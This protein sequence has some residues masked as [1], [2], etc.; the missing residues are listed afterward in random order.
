MKD[1]ITSGAATV[2]VREGLQNWSVDRVAAEVGCAKG[3]V[4]YH[5]RTKK[6]LLGTVAAHLGRRRLSGRLASLQGTGA[7]ALDRLWQTL[8]GEVRSGEWAAWAALTA[9]PG[10]VSPGDPAADLAFF[11]TAISRVLEVPPFRPEEV[12]LITAA[13]DGFQVALHLGAPEEFIREA[14][15]RL[16]LALLP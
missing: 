8:V 7:D 12:R 11:S 15:H 14:Y 13:L 16:W 6:S 9:E 1:K 3:L 4:A 5:H 10:I 2:L